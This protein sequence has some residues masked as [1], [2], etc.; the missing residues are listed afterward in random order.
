M[1][2]EQREYLI[3]RIEKYNI[4]SDI[5]KKKIK[6]DTFFMGLSAIAIIFNTVGMANVTNESMFLLQ[7]LLLMINGASSVYR[8]KEVI[9]TVAHKAGL[10]NRINEISDQLQLDELSLSNDGMRR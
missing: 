7:S 4:E 2:R 5:A 1:N 6:H 3:T 8:F 10:A 9:N